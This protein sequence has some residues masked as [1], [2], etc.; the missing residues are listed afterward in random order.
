MTRTTLPTLLRRSGL[1]D[2]ESLG[3]LLVRLE[4]LNFYDS[5][6]YLRQICL[7]GVTGITYASYRLDRPT[8]REVYERL[9]ALTG[10]P[11]SHL[12]AATAHRFASILTPVGVTAP[13][14]TLP[15]NV[16]VPLVAKGMFSREL[17]HETAAAWCPRCLAESAYHR[18]IWMPIAVTIC[19]THNCLLCDRCPECGAK[20]SIRDI[21][22]VQ[23]PRCH[24]DL[25]TASTV[26]LD[27]DDDHGLWSQRIIQGW[28]KDSHIPDDVNGLPNCH[29]ALLYQ[30][31][32]DLRWSLTN[33][34]TDWPYLH[35]P[36]KA[37]ICLEPPRGPQRS[38][39]SVYILYATSSKALKSWPN[40]FTEFLQN[41]SCRTNNVIGKGLFSDLGV[42]Y[43]HYL[44]RRW[45]NEAFK[46]VQEAFNQYL[47]D[48]YTGT[49]S[50][51]QSSRYHGN[52][53][54]AN[55][56]AYATT[57][58]AAR[59]L[60]VS[61]P[62]I[63]QLVAAGRLVAHPSN[64]ERRGHLRLV[65][66]LEVLELRQRWTAAVSLNEAAEILGLSTDITLDLVHAGLLCAERG[67]SVDGNSQ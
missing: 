52:N 31:V 38:P 24:S 42:I 27:P 15:G 39:G 12:H 60:G 62:M 56:F 30:I 51:V 53:D 35:K 18:L 29:P 4:A 61:Q 37:E 28:L 66:R 7:T 65:Q 47:I 3:S 33:I 44:E 22:H 2:D 58:E 9:A 20:I 25:T 67:P 55:R 64:A 41:Y 57:A 14:I 46:F 8:H 23:C 21:V 13:R 17:R 50:L 10:I 5:H 6:T 43:G 59:L 45:R 63:T 40:G 32:N 34:S 54:L 36:G 16:V 11:T 48:N 49:P 1:Q 19:L 26:D